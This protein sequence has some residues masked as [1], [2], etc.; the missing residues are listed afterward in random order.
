MVF[1]T[2]GGFLE[3]TF[4]IFMQVKPEV[5]LEEHCRTPPRICLFQAGIQICAKEGGREGGRI[6]VELSQFPHSSQ[7]GAATSH[8]WVRKSPR[9]LPRGS[10]V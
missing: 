6:R 3:Y 9:T 10:G 4:L 1:T 7:A 2:L 5:C 8:H